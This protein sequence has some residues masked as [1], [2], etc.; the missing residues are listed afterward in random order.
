MIGRALGGYELLE[1]LGAGGVGQVYVARDPVL[2]RQVAIKTL[3]PEF[4]RDETFLSRFYNEA[5]SLGDL[6]HQNITTLHALHLEGDEPFMVMELVRGHTLEA[7][8]SKV[9]RLTLRESLAVIVQAVA[10]LTT[11]HRRGV[12]HRDIKPS[13]LMV[14]DGGLLKIMDFGIARVRGSQR[15]TRAGQM[16][17][18]LLYAS[19]EQI[20]GGDVDERSDVY[21]LAVVLYE[22]LAGAP[23]FSA[24][25][26]LAL[27][28]AHLETP[29]PP[30]AA[31]VQDIDARVEAALMRALA[32]MPD[33]RFASVEE[34]GAAVSTATVRGDATEILREC[35]SVGFPASASSIRATRFV[36]TPGLAG[37][38]ADRH[39]GSSQSGRGVSGGTPALAALK[40]SKGMRLPIAV[41]GAV[42][43]IFAAGLGYVIWPTSEPE[44]RVARLT[45]S[46]TSD[47]SQVRPADTKPAAAEP[48]KT[49]PPTATQPTRSTALAPA[50]PT[51]S[52]APPA[53]A[54]QTPP[55]DTNPSASVETT[56]STTSAPDPKPF[57][58]VAALPPT[59]PPT[60]TPSLEPV[61]VPKP[62]PEVPRPAPVVL[63]P[64]PPRVQQPQADVRG[65]VTA[66]QSASRIK[67]GDRWIDLYGINDPT[68]NQASHVQAM[69]GY[70]N[71]THGAVDCFEKSGG[72]Y[73]CYAGD[74]D[75]SASALR[76]RIARPTGDAAA[77]SGGSPPVKA[78]GSTR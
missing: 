28:T 44:P 10:G 58:V 32:K 39:A 51:R 52:T 59:P 69:I 53:P 71:P 74:T 63:P 17:G 27:M 41:L 64:E 22:M 23:P 68:N 66:V 40:P 50:E 7:L 67:V 24:E 55:T 70:L 61:A 78:G 49:T 21:S 76:D 56:T 34:F 35:I 77:V 47:T 46:A 42:I 4:S 1:L 14:T 31:Q 45:T 29:P 16:F 30:L 43:A 33:Q 15:M 62:P 48:P 12:I 11:A 73:Q 5:Q 60:P 25:N 26:D 72:R 13:N 36:G 2:G 6:N 9:H 18:T 8:L 20:R 37:A 54:P 38:S 19:P 75:L 57:P 65:T 3:R